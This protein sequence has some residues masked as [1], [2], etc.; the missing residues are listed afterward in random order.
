MSGVES[1]QL[2][3][4]AKIIHK[5]S[6]KSW[7]FRKSRKKMKRRLFAYAK[8]HPSFRKFLRSTLNGMRS[9]R[10]RIR[11]MPLQIGDKVV[12]FESYK[13]L[14]YSCS[15]RAI[16]EYMVENPDYKE[17]RFVWSFKNPRKFRY[18]QRLHSNT[19]VV[20]QY[21]KVYESALAVA[22][23]WITNYRL[24]DHL[25]PSAEQIYVQCWHGTPMKRLGCD[26]ELSKNPM[27]TALEIRKKYLHDAKRFTYILSPSPFATERFISAWR[28]NELGKSDAII[29]E[30]Y[31]R[32]DAL[33]QRDE[34][35]LQRLRRRI[36]L[37]KN[38]HRKIILYAPTWR[39]NQ[40]V[41]GVG[42]TYNYELDMENLRRQLGNEYVILCRLHYLVA[43]KVKFGK[44]RGFAYDVS[45]TNDIN[46]LYQL[47][48]L[49]VTDYSS[50]CFDYANLK[51]PM[52][53]YMYDL[54]QYRDEIRGFYID[55]E[56]LPGTIATSE[57]ELIQAILGIG[58]NGEI[59]QRYH[60]FLERFAPRDDGMAAQRVA[61]L[62]FS[63][64][65]G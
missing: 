17:F 11:R 28:L 3:Q 34:D 16:Y 31:P 37:K 65:K 4:L 2:S 54:E 56:E 53:F 63:N 49:L 62:I 43:N 32:N 35:E 45:K 42:Y 48:D 51:K 10:Y 27:N 8:A 18:L 60:A 25:V 5:Q 12:F 15:P 21:G 23:Y 41:A 36:G 22:K 30:G 57:D 29:E 46:G 19:L 24:L 38:D 39:D 64:E 6:R 33:F 58:E 47:S 61:E 44:F 13:G 1:D 59:D 26:L 7:H 14:S 55:L 52:I 20:K 50:V 9:F 40:H